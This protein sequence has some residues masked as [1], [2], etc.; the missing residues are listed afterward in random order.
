MSIGDRF[1]IEKSIRGIM[2]ETV[3]SMFVEHFFGNPILT[4]YE[5]AVL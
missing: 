5:I 3:E 4:A 1:G 2:Q